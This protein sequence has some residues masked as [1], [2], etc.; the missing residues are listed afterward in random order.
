MQG[1]AT[2][3]EEAEPGIAAIAVPF[4]RNDM[5]DAAVA[6]TMSVA[7]PTLRIRPARYPA[8]CAEL[9]KAAADI[10]ALWPVRQRMRSGAGGTCGGSGPALGCSGA[11]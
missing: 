4:F 3:E 1:F 6:G 10:S 9:Q 7:G 5:P 8:L 2:A 11:A